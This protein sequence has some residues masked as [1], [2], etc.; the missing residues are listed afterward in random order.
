MTRRFYCLLAMMLF[1][2]CTNYE[3]DNPYDPD[4]VGDYYLAIV[5]D[6]LPDTLGTFI[7][8]QV[9]YEYSRGRDSL[10]LFTPN[11]SLNG[12]IDDSLFWPYPASYFRL[13]FVREYTGRVGITGRAL[14]DNTI[15]DS[16]T[17]YTIHPF[18]VTSLAPVEFGKELRCILD[19]DTPFTS[20]FIENPADSVIWYYNTDMID[21]LPVSDTVT[22]TVK[23]C[24]TCSVTAYFLDKRN[25]K[26]SAISRS[27]VV[28][29]V[30]PVVSIQDT[31]IHRVATVFLPISYSDAND[32][33]DSAFCIFRGDTTRIQVKHTDNDTLLLS[34]GYDPLTEKV[35]VWVRDK[36]GLVSNIDSAVLMTIIPEF[37]APSIR[38]FNQPEDTIKTALDSIA[39]RFLVW[40]NSGV[41][42]VICSTSEHIHYGVVDSMAQ[43]STIW[44]VSI[45]DLSFG[46]CFPV[47]ACAVDSFNNGSPGTTFF[48]YYDSTFTD[49]VG[50]TIKLIDP[51]T[52]NFR[53]SS[54]TDTVV[55]I[56]KDLIDSIDTIDN[57]IDTVYYEIN[58]LFAGPASKINDSTYTFVYT[59]S[60]YHNNTLTIVARDSSGAYN[61][62]EHHL[63]IDYNTVPTG[64]SNISPANN[65][66]NIENLSGVTLSWNHAQDADGDTI[67]YQ[68]AYGRDENSL[69]YTA[70]SDNTVTVNGLPGG[71]DYIWYVN[72]LTELDTVRCPAGTDTYYTFRTTNHPASIAVMH[73]GPKTIND[74]VTFTVSAADAEGI[75]EYYWDFNGDGIHDDTI[76]NVFDTV[77]THSYTQA[78]TYTVVA[79]VNDNT[80]SVTSRDTTIVITNNSPAVNAYPA[81]DTLYVGYNDTI[82][83]TPTATDDGQVVKYE[84][85][86]GTDTTFVNVTASLGDTA[87]PADTSGLPKVVKYYFR[88]TDED[89]NTSI[90]SLYVHINML[91]HRIDDDAWIIDRNNFPVVYDANA[92]FVLGGWT[93]GSTKRDVWK[94]MDGENWV[95]ISEDSS[96]TPRYNHAAAIKNDTLYVAGGDVTHDIW[97]STDGGITWDSIGDLKDVDVNYQSKLAGS[98]MITVYDTLYLIGGYF[99]GGISNKVYS[100]IDGITWNSLNIYANDPAKRF[101]ASDNFSTFFHNDTVWVYSENELWHSEPAPFGDLW[102]KDTTISDISG[103]GGILI[104]NDDMYAVA[105]STFWLIKDRGATWREITSAGPWKGSSYQKT[106]VFNNKMWLFT[107]KGI[108]YS[109]DTP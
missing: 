72:V 65:A 90:D 60:Q 38:L 8:Y 49:M 31:V 100:S 9:P 50:P 33:V 64:I 23:D 43:D 32:A 105:D 56:V 102:T 106:A 27:F 62:T 93:T 99:G 5:W 87:F 84:W 30:S 68:I 79:M 51:D 83:L 80:D 59:L 26:S 3:D 58:G 40:D 108:W 103:H 24:T 53:I 76:S 46:E 89:L 1:F 13:Y 82:H 12:I 11:D 48:A 95:M 104:Y 88:A 101:K 70:L 37:E 69:V 20:R 63:Y 66:D 97:Q 86:F 67:V 35:K 75:K 81:S 16:S 109:T 7:E 107:D 45:N 36:S 10:Y 61:K 73:N 39:V 92:L 54:S 15:M 34:T 6:S 17:V 21:T 91:W 14:N 94:S 25:N 22:Y 57:G 77:V 2:V 28:S 55:C 78:N 42:A 19:I 47:K 18:H 85:A 98:R 44:N 74:T 52:D 71:T 4:Y 96:F 29:S 41:V